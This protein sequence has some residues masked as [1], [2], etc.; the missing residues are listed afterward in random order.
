MW[1]LITKLFNKKD[2]FTPEK[3]EAIREEV[4]K[5]SK[6]GSIRNIDYPTWLA[7]VILMRKANG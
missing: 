3:Y 5:L 1:T 2:V 6:V 4:D 7:N